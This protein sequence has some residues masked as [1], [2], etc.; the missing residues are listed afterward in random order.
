[1]N[2][3]SNEVYFDIES[4]DDTGFIVER[5]QN[6]NSELFECKFLIK[7]D[8]NSIPY[9]TVQKKTFNKCVSCQKIY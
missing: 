4:Y 8:T 6:T 9:R 7:L 1:M 5:D 2:N 3:N